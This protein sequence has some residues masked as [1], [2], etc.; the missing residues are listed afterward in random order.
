MQCGLIGMEGEPASGL[1][2]IL[3]PCSHDA[4]RNAP[5]SY[6]LD[7]RVA[8]VGKVLPMKCVLRVLRFRPLYAPV[9]AKMGI[10]KFQAS[11]LSLRRTAD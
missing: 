2:S 11:S 5:S 7:A 6:T 8:S 1:V 10:Q 4:W 3:R 9:W